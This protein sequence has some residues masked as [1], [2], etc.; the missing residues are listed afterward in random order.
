MIRFLFMNRQFI[1]S[2]RRCDV[3]D[4]KNQIAFPTLKH[5]VV[6]DEEIM[7]NSLGTTFEADDYY[8]LN[9]EHLKKWQHEIQNKK[10]A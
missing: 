7:K 2:I 8:I 9:E 1:S 3:L 5:L 4:N 6:D 10:D